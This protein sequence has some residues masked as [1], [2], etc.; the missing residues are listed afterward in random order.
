MV[1]VNEEE[2]AIRRACRARL[3][4]LVAV[5]FFIT[6]LI[7]LGAF[8]VTPWS[9]EAPDQGYHVWI[10][11]RDM[12]QARDFSNPWESIGLF[13]FPC[14]ALLAL[15]SP[16]LVGFLRRSRLAWWM[17]VLFSGICLISIGAFMF[18][19]T[20]PAPGEPD[21]R[22]TG[23]FCLAGAMVL[24]FIGML[25]VRRDGRIAAQP[26]AGTG[27]WPTVGGP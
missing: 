6:A 14:F 16:F 8:H 17:L 10:E 21:Q 18:V 1:W 12:V 19:I 5:A 13:M 26:D 3:M 24:N 23:F 27:D 7:A 4:N 22:G 11:F 20:Q 15:V 9:K 25:F 2:R